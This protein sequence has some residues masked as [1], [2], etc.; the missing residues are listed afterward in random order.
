[1]P[2][3]VKLHE[4]MASVLTGAGS[5]GMAAAELAAQVNARDRYEKGDGSPVQPG[6]IRLR[7]RST[8]TCSISTVHG[9][10]CVRC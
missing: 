2:G 6:Q 7:A 4:E 8:H 10:G 5:E 1:M 3:I 9:S